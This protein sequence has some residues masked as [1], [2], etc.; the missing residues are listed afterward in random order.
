MAVPAEFANAFF[1]REGLPL[2]GGF[3]LRERFPAREGRG[4]RGEGEGEAVGGGLDGAG[5]EEGVDEGLGAVAGEGFEGRV[6]GGV[7]GEEGCGGG[8]WLGVCGEEVREVGGVWDGFCDCYWAVESVSAFLRHAHRR[9][10]W[11]ENVRTVFLTWLCL[12]L[13]RLVPR[14]SCLYLS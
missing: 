6:E 4:G 2:R 8:K 10:V 5:S 14:P 1:A 7:G 11:C 3:G 13:L 9:Y 12:R